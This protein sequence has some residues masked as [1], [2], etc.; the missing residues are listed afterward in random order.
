M[1]NLMTEEQDSILSEDSD[2][3]QLQKIE[4]KRKRATVLKKINKP[5]VI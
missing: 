2:I 4:A 5:P 1:L 3:I